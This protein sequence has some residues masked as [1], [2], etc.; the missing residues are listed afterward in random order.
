M[1]VNQIEWNVRKNEGNVNNIQRE[2]N[3]NV[4]FV[5]E[6]SE[7]FPPKKK[8]NKNKVLNELF[9]TTFTSSNPQYQRYAIL[10]M[11]KGKSIVKNSYYYLEV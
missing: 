9:F 11:Y 4:S 1:R 3:K 10:Y 6:F 7:F 2:I 8:R 5:E